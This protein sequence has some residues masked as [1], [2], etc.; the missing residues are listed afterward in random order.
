MLYFVKAI[1]KIIIPSLLAFQL[2]CFAGNGTAAEKAVRDGYV[3][4][5]RL[6][7]RTKPSSDSKVYFVLKE[8]AEIKIHGD[9]GKAGSWVLIQF[10]DQK[11][12]VRNRS[13]YI[14]LAAGRPTH[15]GGTAAAEKKPENPSKKNRKKQSLETKIKQEQEKIIHFSKKEKIIIE[16]LN[17]IDSTLNKAK[18]KVSHISKNLKELNSRIRYIVKEKEKISEE[19]D[20]N[21]I[22]SGTRLN[23][24]YRMRMLGKFEIVSEPESL[25]DFI[26]QQKALGVI[27]DSDL[28]ILDEQI[29]TMQRY[30]ALEKELKQKR[31]KKLD[32]E[33]ELNRQILIAETKSKRKKEILSK[34]KTEKKLTLAA[35][36]SLKKAARELDREIRQMEQKKKAEVSKGSLNSFPAYKGRLPMPVKG[37]IIS[38][39]GTGQ[40]ADNK[41]FTFQSG[42][43]IRPEKDAYVK[44]IFYGKVIFAKWFR[45]YG[46]LMIVD[47]GDSYYSLYAH[48]KELLK[49]QGDTVEKGEVISIAGDTGS[50][51]GLMLHFEIRHHGK[52]VNP[53]KWLKKGA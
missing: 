26:I 40:S 27:I 2:I 8:G 42:I 6:N 21:R 32:L 1:T 7:V 50:I 43:D 38:K 5:Y 33:R 29:T 41:T 13:H 22:Y 45:G 36:K 35:V 11:G 52:P 19:Y 48:N 10:E 17:E 14:K 16:G 4:A 53:L 12:Y 20:Q 34:I 51:K 18:V 9:L 3:V 39:F 25:F 31:K 28:K 15:S 46:N 24:L 37:K 47:H 23:A 49:K 44:T 30:D